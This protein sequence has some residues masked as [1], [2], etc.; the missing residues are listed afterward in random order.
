MS[1]G[2]RDEDTIWLNVQDPPGFIMAAIAWLLVVSLIVQL[3][4]SKLSV[5]YDR[6][7]F[8]DFALSF[9]VIEN[10]WSWGIVAAFNSMVVLSLTAHAR[11][12]VRAHANF[13]DLILDCRLP[14]VYRSRGGS[15]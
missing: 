8:V 13:F 6:Q 11:T 2:T 4:Y 14:T 7:I 1:W 10:G 5:P 15:P 12:M 3:V 9:L